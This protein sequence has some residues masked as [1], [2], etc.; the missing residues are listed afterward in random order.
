MQPP[1]ERTY[2][3]PII[4]VPAWIAIIV[5]CIAAVVLL[6]FILSIVIYGFIAGDPG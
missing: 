1:S 2:E 5:G 3:P 4:S 6:R